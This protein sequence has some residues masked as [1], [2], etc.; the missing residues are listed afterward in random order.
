MLYL[1]GSKGFWYLYA[2]TQL[3][4]DISKQSTVPFFVLLKQPFKKFSNFPF[5]ISLYLFIIEAT[6]L[7]ILIYIVYFYNIKIGGGL[8]VLGVIGLFSVISLII[9]S[10]FLMNSSIRISISKSKEKRLVEVISQL[11]ECER[12]IYEIQKSKLAPNKIEELERLLRYHAYL[13][14]VRREVMEVP[15]KPPKFVRVFELLVSI[16]PAGLLVQ[17]VKF[18]IEQIISLFK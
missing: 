14:R 9:Y 3:Y 11:E 2:V 18:V 4:K 16:L 1:L 10:F 12:R 15:E 5:S 6:V 13:D 8:M 17:Y 7:P